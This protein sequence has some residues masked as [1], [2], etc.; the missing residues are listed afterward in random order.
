[1]YT[2]FD[3]WL[4]SSHKLE[5]SLNQE[6]YLLTQVYCPPQFNPRYEIH[7]YLKFE[8]LSNV[9]KTTT[10][11]KEEGGVCYSKLIIQLG[12]NS[13]AQNVPNF[14]VNNFVK[15]S[16]I[17]GAFNLSD[18]VKKASYA[19]Q[20]KL[21]DYLV[22][23]IYREE[24]TLLTKSY[25]SD[26]EVDRPEGI[27]EMHMSIVDST[28][29]VVFSRAYSYH[30]TLNYKKTST[31]SSIDIQKQLMLDMTSCLSVCVNEAIA[32]M[33]RDTNN[34]LESKEF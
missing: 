2:Y 9:L 24:R 8:D 16:E 10:V 22:H 1:V 3:V 27:L 25:L 19:L 30:K 5:Q 12:V 18:S 20:I 32:E 4:Y 15:Q 31:R 34:F 33:I 29:K 23:S 28:D 13:V 21:L 7:L 6:T 17:A 26:I 14:I 11:N